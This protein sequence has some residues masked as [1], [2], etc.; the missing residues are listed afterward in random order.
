MHASLLVLTLAS[1]SAAPQDV[2]YDFYS[3]S[4]G[5][6]QMMM[7]TVH[8]LQAEGLPVV[9]INIGERP[10]LA[11]RF[12]VDRVPMFV[13]VIGG[14]ER[15]RVIGWQDESTLR[16]MLAQ[17]PHRRP[18]EVRV[19]D[20]DQPRQ[21]PKSRSLPVRLVDDET[22]P[23]SNW[24]FHLPLPSFPS[25]KK[26]EVVQ[27]DSP[28]QGGGSP[29]GNASI[30]TETPPAPVDSLPLRRSVGGDE[31]E[32]ENVD[33]GLARMLASSVRIRVVDATGIF[34]GSGVVIESEPGRTIIL[35][36]GHILRDAKRDSRI[37]VDV[38]EGKRSRKYQGRNVKYDP[39]ADLGLVMIATSTA[40]TTSP[41]A[42][43]EEYVRA[44]DAVVSIGCSGG[45]KP[46]VERQRVTALNR[47]Q[48][49][50]TIECTGVPAQGRSG[51]G[52]FTTTGSVVGVCTNADPRERRGVY[53]GLKPVYELAHRPGW[54]KCCPGTQKPSRQN[55]AEAA[56]ERTAQATTEDQSPNEI[57]DGIAQMNRARADR[58]SAPHSD[59]K[60][61]RVPSE[62]EAAMQ[63]VEDAEVICIIRPVNHPQAESRVVIVNRASR[64]FLAYLNGE[65]DHVAQSMPPAAQDEAV[66]E[67][68]KSSAV[69]ETVAHVADANEPPVVKTSAWKPS[70]SGR[71]NASRSLSGD[72]VEQASFQAPTEKRIQP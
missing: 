37:E 16:E 9:K 38:F 41:I 23:K 71:R 65:K 62:P 3:T 32:A 66:A 36:C 12:G 19:A 25:T 18:V 11:Q 20:V 63:G 10:D 42:T 54:T 30:S 67:Q 50:D 8:Q 34:Y 6:C 7:P 39:E 31:A 58:A 72:A 33:P 60:P 28:S 35:T 1:L 44:R 26:D 69:T 29:S 49:P 55:L 27:I 53:A 24:N 47:Y 70:V 68:V 15:Q 43:L 57:G 17:I 46:S 13:L 21:Q 4:C 52:L 48:G 51:G 56:A 14:T 5:P 59:S 2:L 22:P 64:R 40:L 45:D 61:G